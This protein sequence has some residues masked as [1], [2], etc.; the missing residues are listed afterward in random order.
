MHP[1]QYVVVKV[2]NN[3]V[4]LAKNQNAEKILIRKGLG[5]GKKVG[6]CIDSDVSFEK[7]FAIDNQ[8]T[9][10]KFNQLIAQIDASLVGICEEIIAMMS[11][12]TGQPVGDEIHVR[13]IDHIAFAVYRL[14]NND[15]IENPFMIEI[16]TL[17][18]GEVAL[19]RKAVAILEKNIGIIFPESEVGFIALHVH[20]LKNQGKL[21][22]AIQYTYLCNSVMEI[23]EDEFGLEIDR[24]SID[25]ARF[26]THLRFAIERITQ[27]IPIKNDLL[28]AIKKMYKTSFKLAKKVAELL[29]DETGLKVTETEIG[30]I[31]MHIERLKNISTYS[32]K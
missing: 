21:S 15:K 28:S 1:A 8:E 17:Y 16:E 32:A 26:I 30:Y 25:Y 12:E 11:N 13:F 19:A 14:K 31:A 7:I 3:N 4:I 10:S 5:F 23:I 29:E 2:F 27:H 24:K 20:S 6:D 9:S 22:N 18:P